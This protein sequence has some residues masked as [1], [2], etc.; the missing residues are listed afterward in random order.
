MIEDEPKVAITDIWMLL[1]PTYFSSFKK[2]QRPTEDMTKLIGNLSL[3]LQRADEIEA[4][5]IAVFNLVCKVF[6]MRNEHNC[7]KDFKY[8][9]DLSI[10]AAFNFHKLEQ[11]RISYNMLILEALRSHSFS[12]VEDLSLLHTLTV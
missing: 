5:A 9:L 1:L 11:V 7:I 8:R 6:E 12:S 2:A 10:F 4:S 3:N